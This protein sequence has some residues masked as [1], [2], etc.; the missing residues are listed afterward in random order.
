M[1]RCNCRRQA[2]RGRRRLMEG[3]SRLVVRRIVPYTSTFGSEH[4]WYYGITTNFINSSFSSTYHQFKYLDMSVRYRPNNAKN[5]TGLYAYVLLDRGGFGTFGSASA[6]SWFKTLGTMPGVKIRPRFESSVQIWRPTE[7][8]TRDWFTYD[9]ETT[10]AA[11]YVCSNGK[12]TEELGGIFEI[13]AR[14]LARGLYF[15]AT[16]T[17][18]LDLDSSGLYVPASHH[19]ELV[20]DNSER[21]PSDPR[22]SSV[23]SPFGDLDTIE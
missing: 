21:V 11:C 9:Q 15:S 14:V 17:R 1:P 18:E 8:S 5:E 23:S 6:A 16:V 2:R 12:E 7:S 10:L 20:S 22:V 19:Q 13:T 3:V 4:R